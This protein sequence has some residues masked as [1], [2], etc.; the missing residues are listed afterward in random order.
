MT[1]G[2]Q[3]EAAVSW[4]RTIAGTLDFRGRSRRLE[5]IYWWILALCF[6]VFWFLAASV[7]LP[8]GAV[9]WATRV[10]DLLLL[11]PCFA[12]FVRRLHDQERPAWLASL[13]PI[14]TL[15]SV[16]RAHDFREATSGRSFETDSDHSVQIEFVFAPLGW[17]GIVLGVM[18]LVLLFMPGTVGANRYGED[19]RV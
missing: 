18:I 15:L 4:R 3:W 10:T 2:E 19:P 5:V 9:I 14:A 11:L 12:L 6:S 16:W 7:L 1:G 13:L 8:I 17:A